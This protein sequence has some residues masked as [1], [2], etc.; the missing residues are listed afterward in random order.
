[1]QIYYLFLVNIFEHQYICSR[2]YTLYLKVD[3]L[4][5]AIK[6]RL[7]PNGVEEVLPFGKLS[8]FEQ[9]GLDAAIPDLIAQ[10]KKGI[11]F[12]KNAV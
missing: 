7:G 5:L 3:N 2:Y 6:I 12:A 4:F 8:E 11:E 9:K 1:M 10:A